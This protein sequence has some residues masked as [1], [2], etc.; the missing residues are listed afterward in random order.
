MTMGYGFGDVDAHSATIRAHFCAPADARR[1]PAHT[2]R[3]NMS[4][5]D[6][7]VGSTGV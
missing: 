3:R 2:A 4:S 7:A 1:A 6:T 5:T